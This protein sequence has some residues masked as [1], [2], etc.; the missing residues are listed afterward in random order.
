MPLD[1]PVAAILQMLADSG[2][3]MSMVNGTPEQAREGFRTMTVGLRDP[4]TLAQV[5]STEDATLPGPGGDIAIRTYRPEA[6][7]LLP[8]VV[9]FHGGGFVIGD[10]D[11]Q[12]DH[13]RLICRDVE[14]VVVSVDYRLAPD[15]PFP[16]GF[17]DCLA[18][19]RWVAEH[20]AD[21]GG[22]PDRI[23]VSGDSAG[24]NLAA[25]VALA[26]KDSGPKLAA[27][28]LLYPGVDFREDDDLHPSRVENGEGFFLTAEDMRWFS[29]HYL[30]EEA[31]R[32][33]PRASVLL[34]PDLSGLPPAVIGTGEY[35][36]LRDEGEAYA[37]A[38]EAAGVK[39]VLHRYDGL[40][41]GFF[42]M[43]TW[44]P[45]S[46]DAAKDLCEEL[47]ALLA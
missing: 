12:D 40:I 10:L 2:T 4:A 20:I 34:A 38:L 24:G 28:L 31:H 37:A 18:A 33:D 46:A 8:T 42:G 41:H 25:A 21:L 44:S 27:Q 23:A 29:N 16:A 35:D 47:R 43:G 13:A 30:S 19:T 7:G 26:C 22:D 15:H 32:E 11:T 39:V 1:P 45:A 3:P 5:R 6:D 14:A 36:P 9:Y 17:E